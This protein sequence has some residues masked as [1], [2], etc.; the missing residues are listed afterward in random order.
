MNVTHRT[1]SCIKICRRVVQ[2]LHNYLMEVLGGLL[3]EAELS[4]SSSV[5]LHLSSGPKLQ[6]HV[7]S[8]IKNSR[9]LSAD[10]DGFYPLR[11][12]SPNPSWLQPIYS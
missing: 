7:K 9:L 11:L 4:K 10:P 8:L 3:S 2:W 12:L 6:I 1:V 5:A